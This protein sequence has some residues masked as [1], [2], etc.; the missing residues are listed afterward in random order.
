M[1]LVKLRK[2]HGESDRPWKF[3]VS[4]FVLFQTWIARTMGIQHTRLHDCGGQ[5]CYIPGR[6]WKLRSEPQQQVFLG[7]QSWDELCDTF[8][9]KK[10]MKCLEIFGDIWDTYFPNW[11]MSCESCVW[12]IQCQWQAPPD[13][14]SWLGERSG[15][16]NFA[17]LLVSRNARFAGNDWLYYQGAQLHVSDFCSAGFFKVQVWGKDLGARQH[18][19]RPGEPFLSVLCK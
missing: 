1:S 6:Q 15:R 2:S 17:K 3:K 9:D 16:L 12:A 5:L 10:I 18:D 13:S 4:A 14:W 19:I 7:A 11:A 8:H